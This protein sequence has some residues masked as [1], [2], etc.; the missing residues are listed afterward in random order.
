M[1]IFILIL[2]TLLLTLTKSF[3]IYENIPL[4]TYSTKVKKELKKI[5]A[6]H[7]LEE[8]QF[9]RFD[10][11]TTDSKI[12]SLTSIKSKA[13]FLNVE[14]P[15]ISVIKN[16]SLSISLDWEAK[17]DSKDYIS[18]YH[19]IY[20][21]YLTKIDHSQE[22][23]NYEIEFE[24]EASK[25]NFIKSWE[26]NSEDEFYVPYGKINNEYICFKAKCLNECPFDEELLLKIVN[27]FLSSK[28]SEMNDAFN[29]KGINAFYKSLPFEELVQKI[30]TQTSTSLCNENNIDLTLESMPEYYD[31][32]G[33][34]FKRKGKLNDL[35][36]TDSFNCDESSSQRFNINIKLIQNI[37]SE[38][39]FNI[40]YEQSN[41][42]STEYILNVENLKKIMDISSYPDS[43]ELKVYAEMDDIIFNDNDDISGYALINVNV[44]SKTDLQTLLNFVLKIGFKFEPTLLNN[45]LNFVLLGKNLNI[46]EVEPSQTIKDQDLLISWIKN[47][48]LV[49][50]GNSE[51]NLFYLDFDLSF[52]FTSNK[53]SYEFKNSYLSIIKN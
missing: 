15:T 11:F 8:R 44:I 4:S 50:L 3:L 37:I 2:L 47:T 22:T 12:Y 31:N 24:M 29:T 49:G 51:Y 35:N 42:P 9:P 7:S 34:I 53:L 40:V 48:Y 32:S 52:Y 6:L 19:S 46:I 39:L 26:Y 13:V 20:R 36:D 30:Y 5:G 25:F 10:V 33:F 14:M 28:K 38:N 17:K 43:T 21:A 18:P 1:K 23:L 16:P 45:G 27:S 41:N